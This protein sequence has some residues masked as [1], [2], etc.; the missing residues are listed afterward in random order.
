MFE[1]DHFES[2]SITFLHEVEDISVD[3]VTVCL[4]EIIVLSFNP[5]G[6][7]YRTFQDIF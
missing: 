7:N 4:G 3:I 1:L 2:E 6:L 5:L